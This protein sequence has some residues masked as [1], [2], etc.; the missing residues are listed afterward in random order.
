MSLKR[1]M[2]VSKMSISLNMQRR[3]IASSARVI[4]VTSFDYIPNTESV[5]H[6]LLCVLHT[7]GGLI[8]E[9]QG[10]IDVN[11]RVS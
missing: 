6:E 7:Y 4:R 2:K 3:I 5:E 1:K 9:S 10:Y 8:G 11:P